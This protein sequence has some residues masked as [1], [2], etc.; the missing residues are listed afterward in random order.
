MFAIPGVACLIVFI[1]A[2]PQEF[3]P[4]LQKVPFLHLFT[5]LCALGWIIDIRLRRLQPTGTPALPWAIAFLAWAIVSTAVVVPDLLISKG[6]EMA[7]LFALYGT[8][9]HG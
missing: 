3:I 4:L 5:A 1:L 7:I 2:R 6:I 9:A 8:I